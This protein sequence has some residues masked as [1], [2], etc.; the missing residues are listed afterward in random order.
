MLQ[1]HCPRSLWQKQ[2]T[3]RRKNTGTKLFDRILNSPKVYTDR[4]AFMGFLFSFL[5]SARIW[6]LDREHDAG[7][8]SNRSQTHNIWN[9]PKLKRFFRTFFRL[10]IF[11]SAKNE[12]ESNEINFYFVTNRWPGAV[13]TKLLRRFQYYSFASFCVCQIQALPPQSN[14]W[15]NAGAYPSEVVYNISL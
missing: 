14:I 2:E 9:R 10:Q 7:L 8:R 3:T 11:P 13:T 5:V 4:A 15:E 12:N 1:R 6:T